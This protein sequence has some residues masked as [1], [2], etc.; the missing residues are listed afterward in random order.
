M[1]NVLKSDVERKLGQLPEV[2]SVDVE[3]MFDPPWSPNRMS[4]AAKL[5][6]GLDLGDRNDPL[7]RISR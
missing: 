2:K 7:V 5:Q 4:D 3:V 6:L 1:A